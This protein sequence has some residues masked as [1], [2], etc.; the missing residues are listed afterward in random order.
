MPLPE[1]PFAAYIRTIGKG[2]KG[3][4][5]LEQS[6]A[7]DAMKMILDGQVEPEQLGAF[8]MLLRV[9]EESPQEIAGFVTACREYIGASASTG[10]DSKQLP[11]AVD[12][13]WSSYAGKRRQLPWYLLAAL[14]LAQNNHRLFMHGASGHT[15]GRIYSSDVLQQLG[16]PV[17]GSWDECREQL[18]ESNFSFMPLE[19]FCRP[20]AQIIELRPLLGLRSPVHTL[21]RL[22]N[23]LSAP[24]SLQSVFHPAYAN[25][26]HQAATLLNEQNAAVFKGEAGEAEYKPQANVSVKAIRAGQ[27]YDYLV[28]RQLS[29]APAADMQVDRLPKVWRGEIMDDY[30]ELAVKGTTAIALQTL[31]AVNEIDE[32]WSLAGQYWEDRN[33][34]SMHP[35]C[36]T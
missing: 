1:H 7:H 33:R 12:L 29:Q 11:I 2:K 25:T 6:E 15:A 24:A 17:A 36:T 28:K 31:G 34:E 35:A 22:L 19:N 16:I 26:H 18:C 13:D 21:A 27:P 10:C 4:R 5:S 23:P 20:L 9:K 30:G 8:L 14:L 32:A 3:R